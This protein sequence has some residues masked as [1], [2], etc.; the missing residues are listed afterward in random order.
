MPVAGWLAGQRAGLAR[1]V[2]LTGSASLLDNWAPLYDYGDTTAS[3][4][5]FAPLLPSIL[6]ACAPPPLSLS[7]F[8]PLA[9]N[10]PQDGD[11]PPDR[12]PS[13]TSQSST[14]RPS[15]SSYLLPMVHLACSNP[16]HVVRMAMHVSTRIRLNHCHGDHVTNAILI[17]PP[18]SIPPCLIPVF[19]ARLRILAWRSTN[20]MIEPT[21]TF[22]SFSKRGGRMNNLCSY[23]SSP[24]EGVVVGNVA[25]KGCI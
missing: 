10:P 4:T 11:P 18:P 19:R 1:A 21:E 3:I 17:H 9:V 8:L 13:L 15:K 16:P 12:D 22:R 23:S 6:A 7:L 25:L 20:L 24:W 2:W 5:S 14:R